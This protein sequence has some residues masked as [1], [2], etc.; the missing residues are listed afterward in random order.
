MENI[1]TMWNIESMTGYK[2]RTTFYEDFSDA[3]RFGI[4]AIKD[5]YCSAFNQW[6]NNIE[7]MAELV[8]VLGWKIA[9]H[10][11]DYSTEYR[12]LYYELWQ[13]AGS[14]VC[15][16]FDGDDLQYFWRTIR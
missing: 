2:P 12:E 13:K 7:Y 14:W 5:T 11:S 1:R 16:H 15:Y 6:Q 4:V 10:Y 3:D 9:E 8:K